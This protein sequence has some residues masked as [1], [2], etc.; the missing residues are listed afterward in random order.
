M[1]LRTLK[2][3]KTATVPLTTHDPYE[4]IKLDKIRIEGMK[5]ARK[6]CRML[7]MNGAPWTPELTNIRV[8]I[9]VWMLV[10]KRNTWYKES[11]RTIILKKAKA[12]LDDSN[13]NVPD[14]F[15]QQKIHMLS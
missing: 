15:S 13:T 11:A 5:Y 8:E 3:Q 12:N 2:L 1:E 14:E 6:R 4:Y 10:L 7:K 9:K